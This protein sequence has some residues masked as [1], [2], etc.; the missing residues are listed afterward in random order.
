MTKSDRPTASL[1]PIRWIV[2]LVT[3][4]V[5]G[6]SFLDRNNISIAAVQVQKEFGLSDAELGL[7]FSAFVMGYAF[8]QPFAGR[9]AD[10]FGPYKTVAVGVFWWS[11]FTTA[12]AL[13]P[14]GAAWS[15]ALLLAVRAALGIGESVIFPASNRLVSS[16]IPFAE[17]GLANGFIFAGVGVGASLAAPLITYM[18]L[19]HD[20]RWAFYASALIGALV[21][22]VWLLTIRSEPAD[23]PWIGRA[24]L[25][26]ISSHLQPATT[27]RPVSAGIRRFATRSVG[28]LSLSY[29]C[30]GYVAYIFFTWFFKY[31]SVVRGMDLKSSALYGALPFLAM[32]AG[33]PLGGLIADVLCRRFGPRIG[34]SIFAAFALA[35]AGVFVVAVAGVRSPELA[36]VV[37][38]GGAGAL[39]LSQSAYWAVS[40]NLGG[41][42][43]GALSGFMN[44]C[45]QIGGIVTASL[46]PAIAHAFGWD[47]SFVFAAVLCGVGALCWLFIDPVKA[48]E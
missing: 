5:A 30:Y 25:D 42:S 47:L 39:Y 16:W 36:A 23:H 10:R 27:G 35:L 24:E 45:N 46:T 41:R 26:H 15:F 43:A 38:A 31:L 13:V 21:G 37:L 4:C 3:F 19:H 12:T 32:A 2:T 7:V 44:M 29:F 14:P 6:V 33:S 20:W 18:I 48:C 34:R 9:M 1:V 8:C 40:A 17:R 22:L 11:L 28:L